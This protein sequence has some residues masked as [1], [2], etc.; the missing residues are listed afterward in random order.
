M[1]LRKLL[2]EVYVD[3]CNS[4]NRG[5]LYEVVYFENFKVRFKKNEDFIREVYE[6]QFLEKSGKKPQ[7]QGKTGG[8]MVKSYC[9]HEGKAIFD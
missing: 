4:E 5:F 7:L 9:T 2:I 3:F 1:R 6:R 8:T